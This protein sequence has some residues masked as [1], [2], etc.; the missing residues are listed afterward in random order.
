MSRASR[1][2][3]LLTAAAC[4]WLAPAAR[5]A[6]SPE[7]QPIVDR[8]V[9]ATGGRAALEA[10]RTLHVKG[11]MNT[12]E[13]RGNFEHWQQAPDR[14]VDRLML[15]SMKMQIG[16]DG[17]TGWRLDLTSKQATI[18]SGKELEKE[19]SEAYFANEQGR[20]RRLGDPPRRR[21]RVARGDAA[22][23]AAEQAVVLGPH[24][25]VDA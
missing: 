18:L 3:L 12:L 24:R 16:Y 20:Q 1:F 22:A 14:V 4:V 6:I 17:T 19:Q 13:L 8:Y 15:G 25:V 11:R 5:A 9:E 2:A 21:V 10:E 23:G 7:A